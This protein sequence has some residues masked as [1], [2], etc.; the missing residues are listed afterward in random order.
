MPALKDFKSVTLW[1]QDKKTTISEDF[2]KYLDLEPE[3]ILAPAFEKAIIKLQSGKEM[4]LTDDAV[5]GLKN[6]DFEKYLDLEPEIILAPAFE[7]AIIKL[8]SGKEMDLTDD[9]VSRLKVLS[10]G[11]E[12]G[13]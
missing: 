8:Q 2:E 7:K 9:A 5:S 13:N 10:D 12:V 6:A 3:I 11:E 4:D 1:L